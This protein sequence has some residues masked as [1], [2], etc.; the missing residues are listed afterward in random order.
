MRVG[1]WVPK[2]VGP[3]LKLP[4]LTADASITIASIDDLGNRSDKCPAN[5]LGEFA[6][7]SVGY[8]PSGTAT[9]LCLMLSHGRRGA[10][11]I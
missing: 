3:R 9:P 1:P 6:S 2:F 5:K 7:A 8:Y 11:S 4:I 10:D